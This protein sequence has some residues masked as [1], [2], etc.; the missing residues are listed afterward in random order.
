M[1]RPHAWLS[2][3]CMSHPNIPCE[4]LLLPVRNPAQCSDSCAAK[5]ARLREREKRRRAARRQQAHMGKA[6]LD[7]RHGET[8]AGA[9]TSRNS[10]HALMHRL[11]FYGMASMPRADP[12]RRPCSPPSGCVHAERANVTEAS[13]RHDTEVDSSSLNLA[14]TA[15]GPRN[16]LYTTCT[17]HVQPNS[18]GWP[19]ERYACGMPMHQDKPKA[20]KAWERFEQSRTS[21]SIDAQMPGK[22]PWPRGCPFGRSEGVQPSAADGARP[23]VTHY[24]QTSST[25][26]TVNGW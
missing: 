8:W 16:A 12:A 13:Q 19:I 23:A 18:E 5:A 22:K 7:L 21:L 6:H 4:L 24:V 10:A 20:N 15:K 26:H 14:R 11:S 1:P 25:P 9:L 3:A 2:R 17:N